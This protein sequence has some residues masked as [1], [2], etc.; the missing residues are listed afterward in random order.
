MT[1]RELNRNIEMTEELLRDK[2]L[3]AN[4][5]SKAYSVS[6]PSFSGMPHGNTINKKT[7]VYA[8]E[9]ADLET[10]IKWLETEIA[11][12]KADVSR[13]CET[14]SDVKI[15]NAVR[16]RFL[17]G[18]SWK[19]VADLMGIYYSESGV[20]TMIYQDLKELQ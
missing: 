18:L 16:F 10:R 3:L 11:M 4:L 9:I 2:E 1:L 14:I 7:E 8:V 12:A 17:H 13:F 6:S 20:K 5:K 19:E 15:R